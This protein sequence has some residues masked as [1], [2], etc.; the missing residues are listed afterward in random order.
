MKNLIFIFLIISL[1]SGSTLLLQ[2]GCDSGGGGGGAEPPRSCTDV[3]DCYS[4]EVCTDNVCTYCKCKDLGGTCTLRTDACP[5][6]TF[7]WSTLDCPGG[8]EEKCCLPD[9]SCAAIGGTCED[10][11]GTCPEGTGAYGSLDCPDG[12]YDQCCIPIQ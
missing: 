5:A 10:W 12:R 4:N 8:R 6:G 3:A 1:F 7:D 11:D 9:T 2:T